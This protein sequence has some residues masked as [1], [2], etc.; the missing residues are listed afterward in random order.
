MLKKST[1]Y[2]NLISIAL[3]VYLAFIPLKPSDVKDNYIV[4]G[5]FFL[6]HAV[7]HVK[8]LSSAPHYVGSNQHNRV[9]T[10][11]VKE[12][13]K[14]GLELRIQKTNISNGKNTFTKVENIFTRIEGSDKNRK[15]LVLMSHY[16]SVPYASPGAG[17]SASGVAVI[18]EGVRAYLSQN[19]TPKN[20]II[21]LFTDAE[22]I[23]L[24]GAQA[25]VD[26]HKW[27]KDIGV[28]LNFEA[29][30][31]AGS[32][33]MFM[34]TNHGNH[35]LLKHFNDAGVSFTNSN[36]LA[37]SIYKMLPN[38]T[39]LTVFRRDKD[40]SGFNFAFIDDHFNYHTKLDN[41]KNLSLDSMAHQAHYLMPLLTKL[42]QIDLT[43][44][45]SEK[46][47]V[48]FQLPFYKTLKYPFSWAIMISL[49]NLIIFIIVVFAGI[50]NQSIKIRPILSAS[51]PLFKS[52]TVTMLLIFALLKFLYWLHPQYGAILQGFTYNGHYYILFFTI[53]TLSICLTFYRRIVNTHNASEI[54]VIPIFIWIIISIVAALFLTG[55]HY[56]VIISLLGTLSLLINVVMKKP[57]TS[58]TLLIMIPVILIFAP[59]I[60]QL[61]VALGLMMVPFSSLLLILIFTTFI[62]CVQIP[63]QYQINKW[64]LITI[65][66]GSFSWA[67][68]HAS[69][70]SERPLPNSLYYLQDNGTDSA[71]M[72]SADHA[73]DEWSKSL[74]EK[75]PLDNQEIQEFQSNH[76]R[77]AKFVTKIENENIPVAKIE[78]I[79]DRKY[80]DRRVY[81]IKLTLQRKVNNINLIINTDLA[82]FNLIINK[83]IIF[84]NDEAQNFKAKSRLAKIFTTSDY[85]FIVE[86]EIKPEQSL[87]L[88]IIEMSTDL[89]NSVYFD[90]PK[91]PNNTIPKPFI[92]TD[93]IITKQRLV[94]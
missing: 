85:E 83:E 86:L 78:V 74:L 26:K 17:D 10:Y 53:L 58:L 47:D 39:D 79:K 63:Q 13:Q 54:M 55:A 5:T 18:L 21:I 31:T 45:Q 73:T 51:L 12:L 46:D 72:F 93:S 90:I 35:N 67:Q 14:L 77:R 30:G 57:Q 62:T 75:K 6:G 23:G 3:I 70:T 36:S 27:T 7:R 68:M 76:W 44:L 41:A 40:I 48:Y 38:D 65:L 61:P 84:D 64:I 50:K 59:F 15:T 66:C 37:Y 89:L 19:I 2:I 56:F 43:T 20:D 82:V 16:D 71:Y 88:E 34:E 87:D 29:R 81:E 80:V 92:Y 22:E 33:Y 28:V 11:I 42:S 32:A 49:I 9:K 8:A 91:R 60:Q 52:I 94:L 69:T 25:F 1:N 24:L 4:D